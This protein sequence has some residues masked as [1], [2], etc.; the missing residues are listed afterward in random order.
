MPPQTRTSSEPR[1]EPYPDVRS[2]LRDELWRVWLR[3]QY[4]IQSQW[5]LGA[6]PR[7]ADDAGIGIWAADDVAGIF[8][9]AL[10]DYS[11]RPPALPAQAQ[12]IEGQ[13][14]GESGA[15]GLL[16]AFLRHT[17]RVDQRVAATLAAGLQLPLCEIWRRFSMTRTQQAALTFALMAELDPKLLVAFRYLAHDPSCRSLDAR[18][19]AMLVYDTPESRVH[20]SR[21]LSP[22]S[23][24]RF[25]RLLE[26][27][28]LERVRESM[29]FRRIRPS[30]RLVQMLTGE[31]DDLDPELVE[32]A[33][34]SGEPAAGLFPEALL[35]T[36]TAALGSSDVLLVMQGQ[37]GVGK[38]HFLQLAAARRGLRLLLI[39]C[40]QLARTS[41]E[42]GRP[43]LRGLLREA[44]LLQAVPVLD[45]VDDAMAQ[46]NDRDEL[47]GF[48]SVLCNEHHGPL[49]LT[50]NRERLPRIDLRP[51]VHLELGT[52]SFP[53][54]VQMWKTHAPALT[55]ADAA[56]L[57]ARFATPGGVIVRATRAA[58][59]S[60]QPTEGPP[61]K[62]SLDLAVRNQLRD[63]ILRLGRRLEAPFDFPDLIVESDVEE[64]LKEITAAMSQRVVVRSAWGFHGAP[65]VSVLFSGAPGVGKTMSAKVLAKQLA[66]E[67]YEVDLSQIVSKW[68]GETEK[69]LS[70]VFDAAEPGHVVLLFNE[71]DSLFGQRTSDVKSSNDRYA[72]LE[73]SYL[74][75]RLERFSGL[76]ILTTNLDKAIDPAF[77]RRFAY[78]VKFSFPTPEMRAELWQ[79]AIPKQARVAKIDF[80]KLSERYQ[81]SGGFIKVAIERSAFIAASRNEPISVDII[82]QT[83]ERMYRE[84]GKLAAIGPIE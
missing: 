19:L 32:I 65:G 78:D 74:L 57:A 24:L 52:P 69:N 21:D 75:Q 62:P 56:D 41:P 12:V 44:I 6:L 3:V 70:E 64:A 54:R 16:T 13:A 79:R 10:S 49:A 42:A 61:D 30:S 18:L 4:Q 29:L 84:R 80:R 28:E 55:E 76:S 34:L 47:P 35:R 8:R 40:R 77:R 39:D 7:V 37:R 71:A 60:R 33:Q 9:S 43:I 27:D 2:H 22:H 67:L 15:Q 45:N 68:I 53:D 23:P 20:L 25:Y 83:V 59:A 63:R 50:F 5:E 81:L 38:K 73:T 31:Y 58:K 17:E 46:G 82:N 48:V 26:I 14:Q 1:E 72:N 11:G 66:L 51:M 36:A